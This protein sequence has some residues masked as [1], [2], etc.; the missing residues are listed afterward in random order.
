M[1]SNNS[2]FDV[3]VSEEEIFLELLK[4]KL[5]LSMWVGRYLQQA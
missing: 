5:S 4:Q 2:L 3:I 1:D